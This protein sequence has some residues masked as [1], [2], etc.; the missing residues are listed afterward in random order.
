MARS[1][2]ISQQIDPGGAGVGADRPRRLY[3]DL[4]G[5]YR[6][7]VLKPLPPLAAPRCPHTRY[8]V[9]PVGRVLGMVRAGEQW[10]KL[11]PDR[12]VNRIEAQS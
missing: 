5:P 9:H 8:D 4:H 12:R 1:G 11:S 7:A 3:F 2:E 6:G 10:Q